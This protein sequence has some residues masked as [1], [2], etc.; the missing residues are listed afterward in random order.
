MIPLGPHRGARLQNL[1]FRSALE[2]GDVLCLMPMDG[3][4]ERTPY[5]LRLQLIEADRLVNPVLPAQHRDV[6]G[7]R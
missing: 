6:H 4:S 3:K 5:A 7:R 1:G 2:S